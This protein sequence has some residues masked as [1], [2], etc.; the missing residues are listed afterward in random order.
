MTIYIGSRYEH[1]TIDFVSTSLGAPAYP[2]VFYTPRIPKAVIYTEHVYVLGERIDQIAYKYYNDSKFW[3]LILDLNP[4]I[5]DINNIT[6][7]TVLKIPN[8]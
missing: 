3:Q 4:S 2:I 8:A 5:K 7:G 1:S 6:P